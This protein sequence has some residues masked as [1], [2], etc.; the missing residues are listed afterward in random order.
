MECA[1][2]STSPTGNVTG[3]EVLRQAFPSVRLESFP[4]EAEM[5][6]KLSVRTNAVGLAN[7]YGV[8]FERAEQGELS[9]TLRFPSWQEFY[10]RQ[11]FASNAQKQPPF[12]MNGKFCSLVAD[13]PTRVVL[14]HSMRT[15]LRHLICDK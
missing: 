5:V 1:T 8:V 2:S 12:W 6:A 14:L 13:T 4:S 7:N 10:T 15:S 3:E 9:Y 11:T